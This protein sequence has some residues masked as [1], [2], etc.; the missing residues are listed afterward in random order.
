MLRK[1]GEDKLS[2]RREV[3]LTNDDVE[4]ILIK[5]EGVQNFELTALGVDREKINCARRAKFDQHVFE[6]DRPH[7]IYPLVFSCIVMK[8]SNAILTDGREL[9]IVYFVKG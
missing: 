9:G 7:L 5:V 2:G 4:S 1:Q 3:V 6:R 8:I